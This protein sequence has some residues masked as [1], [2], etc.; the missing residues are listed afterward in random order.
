MSIFKGQREQYADDIITDLA[1]ALVKNFGVVFE[2]SAPLSVA[3][4][5]GEYNY[6]EMTG[7][8]PF[9]D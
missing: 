7:N 4:K 3:V 5:L 8:W 9:R 6:N 2:K 1:D